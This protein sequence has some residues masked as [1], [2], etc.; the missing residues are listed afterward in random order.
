MFLLSRM[1]P[2]VEWLLVIILMYICCSLCSG[3]GHNIYRELEI[4]GVRMAIPIGDGEI[5]FAAGN[6]K[7][8]TATVRGGAAFE[9]TTTSGGGLFSGSTGQSKITQF[10]ANIQLNEGNIVEI[11]TSSNVS[12][13]VKIAL[14]TNLGPAVTAP[15]FPNSVL[16]T[17]TADIHIGKASIISNNVE[18]IGHTGMEFV[19]DR[20]FDTVDN[21]HT[22]GVLANITKLPDQIGVHV[23]KIFD[24]LLW[25]VV[26]IC[27]TFLLSSFIDIWKRHK[28]S[29]HDPTDLHVEEVTELVKPKKKIDWGKIGRGIVKFF[30]T[31]FGLFLLIPKPIR[32]K[33]QDFAI[34]WA[35]KK[36]EER[37][38]KKQ[39]ESQ[40]K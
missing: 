18:K 32:Q 16:Q 24:L 20:V 37:K 23:S 17:Q 15:F 36:M 4:T 31:C 5:G 2:W 9:T 34:E 38:Q 25:V 14:A 26:A 3:C 7:A 28:R 35:K 12:D 29:K 30:K 19:T 40:N 27:L 1:P 8:V 11:M 10:K 33:M 39:D 13:T 21:V 22:N 6:V